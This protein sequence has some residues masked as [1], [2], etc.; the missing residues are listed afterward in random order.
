ME[1][2]T[3]CIL[4]GDALR[5]AVLD[6]LKDG[7]L[8]TLAHE[9]RTPLTAMKGAR[10]LENLAGEAPQREFLQLALRTPTVSADRPFAGRPRRP[11]PRLWGAGRVIEVLTNL[12]D[13]AV[14]LAPLGR[15]EA[16]RAAA[17]VAQARGQGR[18]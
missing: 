14:K 15:R 11:P 2:G 3:P 7:L 8:A 4:D 1:R 10:A 17:A 18:P 9:L 5:V 13:N 16:V 6:A 12:L